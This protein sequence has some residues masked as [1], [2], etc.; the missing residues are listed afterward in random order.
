MD[1]GLSRAVRE[2]F[3][4]LHE[5][6]LIYREQRLINWCPDCRTALSDLEVEHEEGHAGEL[7]SFAYPLVERPAG[8][9][10]SW[11]PPPARRPCS[12]DTAVAVHPDDRR[13]AALVGKKV[14]HPLTGREFPVIADADPGRHGVRHRRGQGDPGPRLQRLRGGQAPRPASSSRSSASTAR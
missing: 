3:V 12:G 2:V 1:E 9:P 11:W 7:W 5:E 13:Y 10:R 8:S 6:G 14:R 4:R